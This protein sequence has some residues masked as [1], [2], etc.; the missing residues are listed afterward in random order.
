MSESLPLTPRRT[1][2]GLLSTIRGQPPHIPDHEL[3]R[4]IGSGSYGEVWLARNVM[5]TYR[6]VKVIYRQTFSDERPY[7]REFNG[8]KKF[9]PVSR[10]HDDLIDILQ[11]GRN[12]QDDCFYYVMEL[13]DDAVSAEKIDPATYEPKTLEREMLSRGRLPFEECLRLGLSL[14]AGLGHLHKHGL[15]HRDIKPSNIIFVNGIPKIADIGLVADVES[16]TSLVG[17]EGFIPP[18]GPGTVQADIYSLGKVLYEISTGHD[19]QVFPALPTQLEEI[20]EQEDFLELNEVIIRACESDP[21]KRYNSA[22]ELRAD[23]LLLQAGKSVK[24]LRLLERRLA[25]LSRIG[26]VA[27]IVLLVAAAAYYQVNRDRRLARQNLADSHVAY[28]TRLIDEGDLS[29]ALPSFAQA[30]RL[31]QSDVERAK[32]HRVHLGVVLRQCPKLIRVWFQDGRVNAAGFS[33]NGRRVVIAG[34]NGSAAVWDVEG[35][36]QVFRL[37]GHNPE[38]GVESACFSRDGRFLLTA[39]EDRTVRVWN[40]ENGEEITAVSPLL[41]PD[42]VYCASFSPLGDR[43]VTACEDGKVRV[44]TMGAPD[45]PRE[46]VAHSEAVRHASFSPDGRWIVTASV[47]GTAKIWRA[48]TCVQA[49]VPMRHQNWVFQACFSPDSASVVT[50]S[51]DKTARVWDAATGKLIT[52]LHPDAPVHS[53]QFSP[54]GRY[55]VTTCWDYDFS[56]RVWEASTGKEAVPPLKHTSYPTSASFGPAGNR[57]LTTCANGVSHLWDLAGN[58]WVAS[59]TPVFYS[60]DGNAFATFEGDLLRV[61]NATTDT[62]ISPGIRPEYPVHDVKLNRDGSRLL[63]I[64]TRTQPAGKTA[65]FGQVWTTSSAQALSP[66]FPADASITSSVLSATAHRMITAAGTVVQIWDAIGGR[67]SFPL[68]HPKRVEQAVLSP[69]ASRLV[70]IAGTNAYLW[71]A[72]TGVQLQ[73]WSHPSKVSHVEF[74]ANGRQVVT[75]SGS[76]GMTKRY[77]Q[78][79]DVVTGEKVGEPFWHNDGVLFAAFSPDG[80]RVVTASEDRSAVVWEIATGKMAGSPLI[81]KHQVLEAH[82]SPDGRWIVSLDAEDTVQVWDAATS[83]PI[84]PRLKHPFPVWDVQFIANGSRIVAKSEKAGRWID[85]QTTGNPQPALWRI[86]DLTPDPRPVDELMLLSQMLSGHKGDQIGGGLPLENEALQIAWRKL[87]AQYPSDFTVSQQETVAW[88]QRE[89]EAAAEAGQWSA[90]VFHWSQLIQVK[91]DD[92]TFRDRCAAAQKRLGSERTRRTE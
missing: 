27:A 35:N 73:V 10:T 48:D 59:P 85:W 23:L 71:N 51:Y 25:L 29:G 21:H 70:T 14:A 17:T 9:E 13:S 63:I 30:L 4:C 31:E 92:Q 60:P 39:G 50:A 44:W 58:K 62:A 64:T 8:I 34:I 36:L 1:D 83:T 82:F 18:E 78:V 72:I 77:A 20:S 53:A 26:L 41:H 45:P 68:R 66:L 75:A 84:T 38:K 33:P 86:W 90:A 28:G 11:V 6:A 32:R 24:R 56:T 57:I 12:D 79:W 15:I 55:I 67:V 5:G 87:S 69:D 19:R 43:I 22:D 16:S 3:L 76:G 40:A 49:G 80:K 7:E 42:T 2:T 89:A 91:P 37:T 88:H 81:H 52:T 65:F 74:S 54:D 61:W 47:D 46:F